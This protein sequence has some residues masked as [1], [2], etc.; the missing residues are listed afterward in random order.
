[1]RA[2]QPQRLWSR[3]DGTMSGRFV[4]VLAGADK[5]N[6]EMPLWS[7]VAVS[8][9]PDMPPSRRGCHDR[10]ASLNAAR[11]FPFSFL[12]GASDLQ[13]KPPDPIQSVGCRSRLA[14]ALVKHAGARIWRYRGRRSPPGDDPIGKVRSKSLRKERAMTQT[15]QFTMD[16][17]PV[18]FDRRDETS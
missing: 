15:T 5:R 1:M 11:A 10:E 2:G 13:R 14:A 4:A 6:V 18:G 8:P 7:P 16:L 3:H 9:S 17:P 12:A